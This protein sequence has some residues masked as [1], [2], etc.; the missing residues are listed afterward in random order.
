MRIYNVTHN[1]AHELIRYRPQR[2]Y[3]N[4]LLNYYNAAIGKEPISVTPEME[5]GDAK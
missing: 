4:E 5:F 3:Y 1:D 2:G